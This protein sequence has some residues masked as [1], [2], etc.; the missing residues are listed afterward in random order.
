MIQPDR[1]G[2]P[3]AQPLRGVRFGVF[4]S[5]FRQYRRHVGLFREHIPS[6]VQSPPGRRRSLSD[7][8]GPAA[9]QNGRFFT[10]MAFHFTERLHRMPCIPSAGSVETRGRKQVSHQHHSMHPAGTLLPGPDAEF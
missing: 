1:Q 7:G 3:P 6:N 5:R 9:I 2:D 4:P 8:I 10:R